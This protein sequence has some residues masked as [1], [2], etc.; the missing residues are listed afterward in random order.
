VI[1]FTRAAGSDQL[2][3]VAS[4]R[5]EPF[6]DGYI[7]Q[8]DPSRLPDGSWREVFNSDATIYGGSNIGNFGA[9]LPSAGGRFQARVPAAGLVVFQRL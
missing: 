9:D 6:L 1:A 5:N 4:L 2:F 8:T 3:V 7:V